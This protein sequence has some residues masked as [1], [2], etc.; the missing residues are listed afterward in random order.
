MCWIIFAS[1]TSAASSKQNE[2]KK[3][4]AECRPSVSKM[5]DIFVNLMCH[6]SL[7]SLTSAAASKQN[8]YKEGI[9]ECQPPVS[10]MEDIFI[11]LMKEIQISAPLRYGSAVFDEDD[12][13]SGYLTS[14][15]RLSFSSKKL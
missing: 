10:K 6:S 3:G 8:E 14:A 13:Q 9:A 5:E 4:I 2:Y 12:T 7:D 11:S 15:C 1:L